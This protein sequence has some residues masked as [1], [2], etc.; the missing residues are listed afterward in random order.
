MLQCTAITRAVKC[1][2][3]FKELKKPLA[4]RTTFHLTQGPEEANSKQNTEQVTHTQSISYMNQI[5]ANVLSP[6]FSRRAIVL[7][8]KPE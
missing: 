1:D 7:Q 8:S 2:H 6:E 4:K 3:F 5:K